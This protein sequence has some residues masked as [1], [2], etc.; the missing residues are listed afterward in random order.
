MFHSILTILHTH[1]SPLRM[2]LLAILI[3][4]LLLQILLTAWPSIP[5]LL[6]TSPTILTSALILHSYLFTPIATTN[7]T[8]FL[9]LL[10]HSPSIQLTHLWTPMM[11]LS[12]MTFAFLLITNL[13]HCPQS[14][15]YSQ[16]GLSIRAR[17]FSSHWVRFERSL[18]K[19][20]DLFSYFC[21]FLLSL[22]QTFKFSWLV[23]VSWQ[24]FVGCC[25]S[26]SFWYVDAFF[27]SIYVT[28]ILQ[29]AILQFIY[30]VVCQ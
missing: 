23:F 11:I 7:R 21:Q 5:L 1:T 13:L 4:L 9:L 27:I 8:L 20:M 28:F 22:I 18:M 14:L 2:L 26:F 24:L 16:K 6:H 15:P 30:V 3:F 19:Y 10:L 17:N 12:I 29:I 25:S